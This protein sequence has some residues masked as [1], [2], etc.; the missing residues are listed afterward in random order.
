MIYTTG[1]LRRLIHPII[2]DEVKTRA[3]LDIILQDRKAFYQDRE[4]FYYELKAMLKPKQGVPVEAT[5]HI[6]DVKST[7]RFLTLYEDIENEV[8]TEL[9]KKVDDLYAATTA[10]D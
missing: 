4:A 9:Q 10:Q 6:E 7:V 1:Q 5:N 3:I 2:N 8:K